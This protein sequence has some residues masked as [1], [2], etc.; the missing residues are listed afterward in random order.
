MINHLYSQQSLALWVT[1]LELATDCRE[2]VGAAASG[3]QGSN[4]VSGG[5]CLNARPSQLRLRVETE[6]QGPKEPHK[7]ENLRF[8]FQGPT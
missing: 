6:A 2:D 3:L 5:S 8:G 1:S 4:V 7:H